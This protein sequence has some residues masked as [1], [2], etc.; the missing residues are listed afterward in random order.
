MHWYIIK[1]AIDLPRDEDTDAAC[2]C[3]HAEYMDLIAVFLAYLLSTSCWCVVLFPIERYSLRPN[4]RVVFGN[5][6][7]CGD[8]IIIIFR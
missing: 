7:F 3:S 2:F 4:F 8:S 6:I 1:A 5:S